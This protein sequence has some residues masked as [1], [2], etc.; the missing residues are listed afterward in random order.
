[1][2][3]HIWIHSLTRLKSRYSGSYPHRR[4]PLPAAAEGQVLERPEVPEPT[5]TPTLRDPTHFSRNRQRRAIPPHRDPTH[6]SRSCQRRPVPLRP[7]LQEVLELPH[8]TQARE[9][10]TLERRSH[11]EE[12]VVNWC[13]T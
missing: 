13:N 2:F 9:E 7:L 10:H 4:R 1:M 5:R 11:E 12:D 8:P 3:V 6:T